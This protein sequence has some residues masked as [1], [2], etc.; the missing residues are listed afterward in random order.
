MGKNDA[1]ISSTADADGAENK[2]GIPFSTETS[3]LILKG[4]DDLSIIQL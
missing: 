2:W 4:T 1:K 3:R